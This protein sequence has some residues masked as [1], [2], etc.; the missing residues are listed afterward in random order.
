LPKCE[1]CAKEFGTE[2]ALAQHRRDKHGSG[3]GSNQA[4]SGGAPK[5][6]VKKQKSLRRRN[7]HTVAIA[8]IGV[9][10]AVGLGIYLVAAPAVESPPFPG[11]TGE[12]WIHV[13]PYLTIQI[14]GAN[15]TI[16]A[17]V[18]IVEGGS[19]FEP[20]HTHDASGL[21]HVELSQSDAG[22]HN[23][24]L[25]DFFTIWNYTAKSAGAGEKPTLNGQPLSVEFSSTDILGFHT[26]STY[27]AV[28]LVDGKPSTQWGSLNVEELDYCGS[29]MSGSPC[30]PTD[31]SS[32]TGP[33]ADP[34]W[35]G[36]ATYPYGTGHTIT[37][38]Y[39]RG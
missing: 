38:E 7:R 32:A 14:E 12:T 6:V 24:T 35:D 9:A 20:I 28:L 22:S 11:I 27:K 19:V 36:T 15:V 39:V 26:N 18:G 4:A 2:A 23:Y 10:V 29:S 33:A 31:C 3:P 34:L 30:C 16:P 17:D 13:H 5:A 37:I 21:L 8:L 1:Y 25:G